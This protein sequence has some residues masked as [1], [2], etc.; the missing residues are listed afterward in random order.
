MEA[1]LGSSWV[2]TWRGVHSRGMRLARALDALP[3]LSA[4]C[5]GK[6]SSVGRVRAVRSSKPPVPKHFRYGRVECAELRPTDRT[7]R[8]AGT[9][10]KTRVKV[11][12]PAAGRT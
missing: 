7:T 12:G 2:R 11:F 3:E 10:K 1:A 4:A 6:Q 5:L 8:A 9:Q